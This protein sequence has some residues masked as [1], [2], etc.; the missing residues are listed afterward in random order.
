M[1]RAFIAQAGLG[2]FLH[3]EGVFGVWSFGLL[4]TCIWN[5]CLF[6]FLTFLHQYDL[7]RARR[8]LFVDILYVYHALGPACATFAKQ[9]MSCSRLC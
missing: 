2:P 7:C 5:P 3:L 6:V 8:E 9:D 1:L 4:E